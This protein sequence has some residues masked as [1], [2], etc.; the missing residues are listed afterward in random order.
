MFQRRLLKVWSVVCLSSFF[1]FFALFYFADHLSIK[2]FPKSQVLNSVISRSE[3]HN[4]RGQR[5]STSMEFSNTRPHPSVLKHSAV[6]RVGNKKSTATH[7]TDRRTSRGSKSNRNPNF[8][9]GKEKSTRRRYRKTY[10]PV[11]RPTKK[12]TR[13]NVKSQ[14]YR[15]FKQEKQAETATITSVKPTIISALTTLLD[16]QRPERTAFSTIQTP[17]NPTEKSTYF[18]LKSSSNPSFIEEAT[19]T[20]KRLTDTSTHRLTYS[21]LE[22][23][24]ASFTARTSSATSLNPTD[25]STHFKMKPQN[26]LSFIRKP[27]TNSKHL[28]DISKHR[29][30]STHSESLKSQ[31]QLSST[32][33]SARNPTSLD[34]VSKNTYTDLKSNNNYPSLSDLQGKIIPTTEATGPRVVLI[35]TAFFGSNPWKGLE[36][37]QSWTHFK[38]KPCPVQNCVVSYKTEEFSS[39]NVVIF[40]GRDM[41]HVNTLRKLHNKRPLNQAWVYFILESPAHS[42]DARQYGG[43]FNWTM[44]YRRDSD[45]YFPYG[46][47]KLLQADDETPQASRDYSL[48]KDKLIVWTVSNCAG[49]RFSYVNK[50]KQFVQVDIFGGCGRGGCARNSGDCSKLLQSYKFQ[51][52]FENTECLDYVTEKYWGSPLENGIVPIVMGGADYKKIA[53]P[54]SY[55]NVLDFPSVK[56]LA[57]YLLYLD[58]NSTAYNEYFS[59][60]RKYKSGGVLQN[61]LDGN[62]HWMCNLCALANNASVKNNVYEHLEQFWSMEQCNLFSEEFNTI[63]SH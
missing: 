51:L 63:I 18:T 57:D 59:W 34:T 3:L 16:P 38:G 46:F 55:I 5:N 61:G 4:N 29:L 44:T 21:S 31:T 2:F 27:T 36:N 1:L 10:R 7:S 37:S 30:I 35:Y 47:F 45:I 60:K 24:Q 32:A 41:P 11:L 33:S 49:K 25:I 26:N 54:G 52:A 17:L 53:I 13:F 20:S 42:P 50:L 40:H 43:L 6:K 58:K 39:S 56:A 15:S 22:S 12:R 48:G 19:T 28:A 8:N 14:S 62:Y 23:T 9:Q